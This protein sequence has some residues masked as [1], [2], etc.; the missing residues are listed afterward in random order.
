MLPSPLPCVAG[1]ARAGAPPLD[2]LAQLAQERRAALCALARS[3]GLT[4]ED[5]VDVVQEALCT[6]LTKAEAGGLPADTG[7][8]G[9]FLAGVVRN[10][11]RNRRRL[12]AV[13]KTELAI[14]GGPNDEATRSDSRFADDRPLAEETLVRAEE[15]VRLRACVAELCEVQRAVV[16]LRMLEERPGDDVGR[17]LGISANHVAVLL[18]RA[19][20]A[21]RA[22]MVADDRA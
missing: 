12:H 20:S 5:A 9:P 6:M 8:W 3:E 4:P 7:T 22:C 16:T 1:V 19:K 18:L 14:E 11:A 2:V 21:L 10:T 15:H 13:T 17:A